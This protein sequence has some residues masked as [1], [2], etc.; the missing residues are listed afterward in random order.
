MYHPTIQSKKER[1]CIDYSVLCGYH[2]IR[3]MIAAITTNPLL[4]PG[5]GVLVS[6]FIFPSSMDVGFELLY[7]QFSK[8]RFLA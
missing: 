7:Y 4:I 8:S 1:F 3:S 5:N 2:I 6:Q